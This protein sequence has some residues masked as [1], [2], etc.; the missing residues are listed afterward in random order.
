MRNLIIAIQQALKSSLPT[1][2]YRGCDIFIATSET[3]HPPGTRFP[4]IGIKDG[5]EVIEELACDIERSTTS[6]SVICWA[7]A[8]GSYEAQVIG[9]QSQPGVLKMAEDVAYILKNN[10]LGSDEIQSVR[11]A[12]VRESLNLV[13]QE[14]GREVQQKTIIF[15]YE[16]EEY[17]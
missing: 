17:E 5:S 11:R 15:E 2:K 4:A 13:D 8:G 1:D 9:D 10:T 7:P 12:E 14:S 16:I 3:S 6:V